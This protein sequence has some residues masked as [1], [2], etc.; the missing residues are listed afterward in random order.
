M[1]DTTMPSH[2]GPQAEE[3]SP[4]LAT[5]IP[6]RRLTRLNIAAPTA[7]SPEP[8]TMALLGMEPKG[9]KKACMEPPMPRLKPV[10]RPKISARVPY[11]TKS[12]ARSLTAPSAPFSTAARMRPP[13]YSFMIRVRPASSSLSMAEKHLAR[14]S[15]W[16][17]WEPKMKSSAFRFRHWPTAADSWPRER[18]AGPL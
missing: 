18:W 6:G 7:M 11:S 16:L 10:S 8:P 9:A 12:T 2:T 15:P 1:A 13:R 3:A 5:T 4:M 17:R 14:I